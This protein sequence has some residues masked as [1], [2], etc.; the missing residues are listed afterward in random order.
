[1]PVPD[2]IQSAHAAKETGAFLRETR[3]VPRPVDKFA[4]AAEGSQPATPAMVA[5]CASTWT[6]YP[7]PRPSG[8]H[9]PTADPTGDP[10][11]PEIAA[12]R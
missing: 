10:A 2:P 6:T 9:A 8:A 7:P 1:M 12:G 11:R 5:T 3:A 4:G